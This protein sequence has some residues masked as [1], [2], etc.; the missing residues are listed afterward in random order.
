MVR[1][2]VDSPWKSQDQYHTSFGSHPSSLLYHSFAEN[3]AKS[4]HLFSSSASFL[5]YRVSSVA[6]WCIVGS[7][8]SRCSNTEKREMQQRVT[9]PEW[10]K[11]NRRFCTDR[12]TN[13]CWGNY[14]EPLWSSQDKDNTGGF[15]YKSSTSNLKY[16]H[17]KTNFSWHNHLDLPLKRGS[18]NTR[19]REPRNRQRC[20]PKV[21][22][23]PWRFM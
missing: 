12:S 15:L 10:S 17:H 9:A 23:N 3:V 11:H 18:S 1:P 21:V 2:S 8:S 16:I 14:E 20:Q 19:R 22:P 6:I 13:P 7:S 5:P 4:F